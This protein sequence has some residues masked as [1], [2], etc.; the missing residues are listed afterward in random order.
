MTKSPSEVVPCPYPEC[1]S[2]SDTRLTHVVSYGGYRRESGGESPRWRCG[3]CRR[4]FSA[5]TGTALA[6]V[7]APDGVFTHA[8]QLFGEG[9]SKA[10]IAR[11]LGCSPSTVSRWIE[12]SA[13]HARIFH[14]VKTLPAEVGEIQMDELAVRGSDE[15]R[16]AWVY[17]A[18][19]VFT[20]LWVAM[21]VS[22]RTLRNTRA[23]VREIM[24]TLARSETCVIVT[25]DG[26]K[27]YEPSMRRV[28][29]NY[30][31]VYQQ[32]DNVYRGGR[33]VRSNPRVVF[34]SRQVFE[35]ASMHTDSKKPNTAFIERL[36]LVQRTCC[37]FLRRRT[38]SPAR[39]IASVQSALEIVRVVYN[40]VRPHQSLRSLSGK[41]TPAMA[42]GL[43]TRPLTLLEILRWRVPGS[44]WR[45]KF[46]KEAAARC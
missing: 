2:H 14:I 28:F 31:V 8:L 11:V 9:L 27:Y 4:T 10:G 29:R 35:E 21:R 37:A 45:Q 33:V 18:I 22:R 44:Y 20:R 38:A 42:A 41:Q 13:T 39:R 24:D 30:P 19:E 36:N 46:L 17:S 1:G 6:R 5:S 3:C 25:S 16:A 12:R 26:M 40:Y 15:A 32:V 23:F 34:G 43:T 7:R